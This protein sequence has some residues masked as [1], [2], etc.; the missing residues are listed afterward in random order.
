VTTNESASILDVIVIGAGFAGVGTAIKLRERGFNNFRVYEK[1][2]GIGGTW[3]H[4]SYPGAACDIA[5]HLYCFSF[6][7]NPNWSRKFSPQAEIQA[8]IEHCADKYDVR[9]YIQL[10]TGVDGV[11]FQEDC[12]LWLARL[13]NG[14]EVLARHVIF[15]TGGLHLPAYP[16]IPGRED[17]AGHSMHS[18]TWNHSV[19]MTDKRV[20]VI[21]SAASAIQLIPELAKIAGQVDV[22]QRTANYI[23]PRGDREFSAREK[24]RFARWPLWHRLYRQLIFLR[25]EFLLFPV[26]KTKQR[27]R[28]RERVQAYITRHI[29]SSVKEVRTRKLLTPN[30]PLGCKRILIADNFY[31]A[32]NR[33]NVT[34]IGEGIDSIAEHG[35]VTADGRFHEADVLVYATG[36]DVD[37][38]MYATEVVGPNKLKLSEMWAEKPTA[39]KGAFVPGL[40]NLYFMSG[41]NTGVGTTSVVYIIE[42]QLQLIMQALEAGGKDKLIQVSDTANTIYNDK[43]REALQNT[44]WAGDCKSWYKREDGEIVTLYP[45]DARTFRKEHRHLQV[46][47]FQISPRG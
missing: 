30:Y 42:A 38:Y 24:A 41:P 35:L 39:Y 33:D 25:G 36:F 40:P 17:F 19:D 26:V 23:A 22:Y 18:A 2:A 32:I 8:Y 13:S 43:L 27:S 3:W 44:V 9:K 14:E 12:Q 15:C 16:D 29:Q 47:D 7:P 5:S 31:E 6:E 28:W 46:G 34:V 1:A 37:N 45:H 20:A 4:N 10:N 21:G 11:Y